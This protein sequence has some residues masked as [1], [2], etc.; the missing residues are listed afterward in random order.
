MRCRSTAVQLRCFAFHRIVVFSPLHR[1]SEYSH[2]Y[3][4]HC[5]LLSYCCIVGLLQVERCRPSGTCDGL[6]C[7]PRVLSYDVCHMCRTSQ[8]ALSLCMIPNDASCYG[9]A[10][11]VACDG[12]SIGARS[13]PAGALTAHAIAVCSQ[14]SAI[15]HWPWQHS[16]RCDSAVQLSLA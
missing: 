10:F 1:Y 15:Q 13:L 3:S 5:G 12:T 8:H 11:S 14:H 4:E 7:Q 2:R 6:R 16:M 9:S